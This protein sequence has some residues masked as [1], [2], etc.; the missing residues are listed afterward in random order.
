MNKVDFCLVTEFHLGRPIYFFNPLNSQLKSNIL[1]LV[2]T[3]GD[4][5]ALHNKKKWY[6]AFILYFVLFSFAS[7][8]FCVITCPSIFQMLFLL[9]LLPAL[10]KGLYL[11]T[12]GEQAG[13]LEHKLL[14]DNHG[15]RYI[16]HVLFKNSYQTFLFRQ[17][18]IKT[19]NFSLFQSDSIISKSI[20]PPWVY[21]F[22]AY[23]SSKKWAL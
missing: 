7:S 21:A 6:F 4:L 16:T 12:T 9:S 17:L 13:K 19:G 23:P 18:S 22:Y 2:I 11:Q 14:K 15:L 10:G 8:F 3:I 5:L 20:S 1:T